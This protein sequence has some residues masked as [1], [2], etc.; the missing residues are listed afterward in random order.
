VDPER[1][2]QPQRRAKPKPFER[3]Q[4]RPV[5]GEVRSARAGRLDACGAADRARCVDDGLVV[6]DRRQGFAS[7]EARGQDRKR[8]SY[9][10]WGFVGAGIESPRD[11][12][13]LRGES[14]PAAGGSGRLVRS[15]RRMNVRCW[16]TAHRW[17]GTPCPARPC[18]KRKREANAAGQRQS[19]ANP[20]AKGVGAWPKMRTTAQG[21][22]PEGR[23]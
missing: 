6:E 4:T 23:K 13:G 15:G 8:A 22:L 21:R 12:A 9:Q 11:R 17:T 7:G 10:H 18:R 14:R 2:A 5:R 16:N 3:L 19:S 1:H 20:I